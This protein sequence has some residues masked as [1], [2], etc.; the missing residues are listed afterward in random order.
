[1]TGRQGFDL[2]SQLAYNLGREEGDSMSE[3][4][5]EHL[6]RA[7]D[8]LPNGFPRTESGVEIQIL[9][10]ILSPEEPATRLDF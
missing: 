5:Y 1:M 4:A 6:A 8:M 3:T 9:K 2:K 10:K 7:L